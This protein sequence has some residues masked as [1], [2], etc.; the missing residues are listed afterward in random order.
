E[1]A[2]EF[3]INPNERILSVTKEN[4]SL[5]NN[6]IG[7]VNLRSSYARIGIIIPPT[8]VDAGFSGK[9]TIEM[10]GS[11]FP[12]KLH[13]DDRFLHLVFSRTISPVENPYRGKYANKGGVETAKF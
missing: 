4:I 5:S 12:I 10:I 1:K 11:E 3:I 13:A 9:L 8:I 6:L 2:Q 7:F